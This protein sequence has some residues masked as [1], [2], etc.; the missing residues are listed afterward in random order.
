MLLGSS[1][2]GDEV[3]EATVILLVGFCVLIP[4]L[5]KSV[6]VMM[7]AAFVDE[8][9]WAVL[10]AVSVTIVSVV[11]LVIVAVEPI[12]VVFV[13]VDEFDGMEED[14]LLVVVIWLYNSVFEPVD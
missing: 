14:V 7:L 13:N 2:T 10:V 11:D 8:V 1:W 12:D 6:Y 3:F 4:V 9:L 5:E